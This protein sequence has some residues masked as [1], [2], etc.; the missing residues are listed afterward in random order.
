MSDAQDRIRSGVSF[1]E[2]VIEVLSTD[3]VH[4]EHFLKLPEEARHEIVKRLE[5][6]VNDSRHHKELLQAFVD[7]Y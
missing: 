6:M 5:V 2:N 3:I 1:E 7:K 4:A